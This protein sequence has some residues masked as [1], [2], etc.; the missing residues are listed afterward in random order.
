MPG[1]FSKTFLFL[2]SYFSSPLKSDSELDDLGPNPFDM[3]A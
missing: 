1:T 2:G 3:P